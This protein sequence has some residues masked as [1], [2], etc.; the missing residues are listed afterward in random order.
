MAPPNKITWVSPKNGKHPKFS[1]H[2][3]MDNGQKVYVARAH[4]Q[5]G[6]IPGKFVTGHTSAYIPFDSKEIAVSNYEVIFTFIHSII[7]H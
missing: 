5:N 3:G 7:R 6:I 4:H 2:A 1:V